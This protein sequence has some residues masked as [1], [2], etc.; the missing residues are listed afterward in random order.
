M[1]NSISS[2]LF[3]NRTFSSQ[4]LAKQRQNISL[5]ERNAQ[6]SSNLSL[7]DS[8]KASI[9]ERRMSVVN[10]EAGLSVQNSYSSE[11]VNQMSLVYRF[12]QASRSRIS[13]RLLSSAPV[14][15][16]LNYLR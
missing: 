2:N 8:S 3:T 16:N 9:M 6:P 15:N 5:S 7:K 10:L 1:N 13:T 11:K 12:E 4:L 14:L